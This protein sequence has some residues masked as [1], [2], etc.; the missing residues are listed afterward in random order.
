MT[1]QQQQMTPLPSSVSALEGRVARRDYRRAQRL[2]HSLELEGCQAVF[3]DTR[4]KSAVQ[5][6]WGWYYPLICLGLFVLSVVLHFVTPTGLSGSVTALLI[7]SCLLLP[8]AL[9]APGITLFRRTLFHC[10]QIHLYANGLVA[11][12]ARGRR[13]GARFDQLFDFRRG[14]HENNMRYGRIHWDMIRAAVTNP[15]AG[16]RPTLKMTPHLP[17]SIEVCALIERNYTAFWLP[18]FRERL[19]AGEVLDFDALLLQRDWLGKT[20]PGR[21]R[22]SASFPQPSPPADDSSIA[23]GMARGLVVMSDGTTPVEWFRR[24]EIKSMRMDD[25]FLLIRTRE[26]VRRDQQGRADRLWFQLDTLGLKD[27]ALLKELVST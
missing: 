5:Y 7:F 4:P 25:R 11:I 20:T 18:R 21:R 2:A 9:V 27:A 26:P 13:Q 17:D 23:M 14:A 3:L 22:F 16:Q 19:Q 1:M 15:R 8:Y 12:D 24:T 10:E 6:H